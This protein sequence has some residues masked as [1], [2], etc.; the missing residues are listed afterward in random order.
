MTV[1]RKLFLAMAA[2]VAS[3]SL[4]HILIAVFVVNGALK[5]M[6]IANRDEEVAHLADRLL[7]YYNA[8]DK[9]WSGIDATNQFSSDDAGPLETSFLLLSKNRELLLLA[10]SRNEA[11]IR[12]FGEKHDLLADGVEVGILYYY[13]PEAAN[14]AKLQYGIGSSV[15][16]ILLAFSVILLLVSL[17]AA[18]WLAKRITAPLQALVPAIDRLGSGELGA[19]VPVLG[20]DEYGKVAESFNAMSTQLERTEI[21]RRSLVADVAHE[22]R[23]PL[24]ILQGQLDLLQQQGRA[25]EPHE[26]LSLQDELIRLGKLVNDL[27]QL[28]M[29]EAHKLVLDRKPG[30]LEELLG[31]ILNRYG[32]EA[33]ERGMTLVLEDRSGNPQLWLDWDRMTQVFLNLIGNAMRYTPDE[34]TIT[35]EIGAELEPAGSEASVVVAAIADTGP[36]IAPEHLPYIFDRFYRSDDARDRNSGGM[37]LGLAI[38]KEFVAVHGGSIEVKSKLGIGTTFIVKLPASQKK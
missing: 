33:E 2:L 3:L 17:I 9:T 10:G 21:A 20:K 29:A 1:R 7:D 11:E 13:H 4:I 31:R 32:E 36:G 37:G 18:Y 19:Q 16:V 24:T 26:L 22:L 38:A 25:A 28:S 15:T 8:H 34:G 14:L 23:T 30:S 5:Y 12:A 6:D 35:V 27:H